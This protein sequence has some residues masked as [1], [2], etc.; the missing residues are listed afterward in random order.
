MSSRLIIT[1]VGGGVSVPRL[2]EALA[3]ILD[4]AEVEL[5]LSARRAGRLQILAQHSSRQVAAS[6]PGWSVRAAASLEAALENAAIVVLLVRVGGLKARA[7]DEEF[8]LQLGVPGDEGLGPGGFANAWRTLPELAAIARSIGQVAPAARVLNL[9]APLGMTTRLLLD[10]G[11]DA[12]GLCELPLLTQEAWRTTAEQSAG[13]AAWHY[14]GLNH[15]GW[16][17]ETG[18][19]GSASLPVAG[20]TPSGYSNIAA[21]DKPTLE[22]YGAAPLR[23]FYEVFD[24]AGALRLGLSRPPSRARQLIDLS[25]R[26]LQQFA[27][28]PGAEIPE[29]HARPTPWL[30]RAVAPAVAALQGGPV[31]Q[32]FANL[33]NEDKIS[34]LPPG[35]VVELAASFSSAGISPVLPGPL[36]P[37]VAR[38]LRRAAA[39]EELAYVAAVRRDSHLLEQAIR[40]LPLSIEE[41]A[42]REL[43]RLAQRSGPV[44]EE[45][46]R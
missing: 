3:A 23:Y 40:S 29:G 45:E 25:E 24:R 30:D 2:C 43:T 14:A 12:V 20:T 31:H 41:S 15:L 19:P 46:H 27:A 7:W 6:R 11:L 38:F 4:V 26:L 42:V 10:Q 33:R 18:S 39:A 1:I 37:E 16:F 36:P 21:I 35:V 17:W 22:K 34:E 5:R 13:G 8:P 32:G 28:T 44:P 9:M